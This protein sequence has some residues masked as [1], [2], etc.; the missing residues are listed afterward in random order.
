MSRRD[1]A[2]L[3]GTEWVGEGALWLDPL[4]DEARRYR[5][6]MH[7]DEEAVRYTWEHEGKTREG[8][9]TLQGQGARWSDTWH[10]PRAV[11]CRDRS[12]AWGLLALRS[13]YPGGGADWG[14]ATTL[15]SRPSGEMVLQMTNIAP[16]GE[17]TRAVRMVLQRKT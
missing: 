13:T 6:T 15:S 11:D 8:V 14:W 2:E 9:F 17:E 10:Q 16:W 4:G 7:I 3:V 1:L 12:G 5:C